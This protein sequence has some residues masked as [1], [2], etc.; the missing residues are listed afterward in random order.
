M[1]RHGDAVGSS[2]GAEEIIRRLE[3][4]DEDLA[5]VRRYGQMVIPRMAEY[6]RRFYAWM[7]QQP[8]WSVFFSD[9]ARLGY[10][11]KR[12]TEHWR[13]LFEVSVIDDEYVARRFRVGEVHAR[14]GLPVTAYVA[15]VD[16]SLQI[17]MRDLNDGRFGSEEL[18]LVTTAVAKLVHADATLVLDAYNRVVNQ[19]IADQAQALLE[20]STPVTTLWD[21]V[22][23][24]P[25]VGIIDSSRA[26]SIMT[27]VLRSI[28]DTRAKVFIIDISGVPVVD[29]AVANHIIKVTRATRLMGCQSLLSG[30]SPSI[31]QTMVDL[32]VDVGAIVTKASMRDAL[33][34]AYQ[35]VGMKLVAVDAARLP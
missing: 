30:V 2:V 15:G 4:T 6:N 3:I 35:L 25:V 32:G 34:T 11:Q 8:E 27:A 19:K 10:V 31:A 24:L 7:E 17:F 16:L 13:D 22:L 29:T 1:T 12:Q 20:M 9:P 33:D 21:N 23:M 26:Q 28:A 14:I 18:L 5:H